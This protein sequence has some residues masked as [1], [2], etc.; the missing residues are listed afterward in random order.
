MNALPDNA[1]QQPATLDPAIINGRLDRLSMCRP[2]WVIVGQLSLAFFFE[3]YAIFVTG[4]IAPSLIH[5]G[6]LTATTQGLFG[7]TGVASFVAALFAGLSI[8]T[9]STG[10]L[11]DALGRRTVFLGALAWF[12]VASA[13]MAFQ[14]SAFGLN[15][16]RFIAGLGLGVEIV[17]I[18]TCI[19]EIVPKEARGRAFA[20]NQTLG[21]AAVPTVAFLSWFFA[22]HSWLGWDG[23][24]WVVAIGALGAMLAFRVGLELPESPRWLAARG[25]L[26]EADKLVGLLEMRVCRAT[27][28]PLAPLT[29]TTATG[30]H[31]GS[32]ADIWHPPFRRRALMLVVFNVFQTVG[33]YGF[34]NWAPTLLVSRGVTIVTSLMYVSVIALAAPLGPLLGLLFADRFERKHAIMLSAGLV[35]ALGLLFGLTSSAAVVIATGVGITLCQNILS[36]SYHA[37]QTELFPTPIRAKAVGFVYTWSRVSAMVSAFVIAYVLRSAGVAGVLALIAG[38]MLVV[39]AVI[40]TFGPLTLGRSVDGD[41]R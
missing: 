14:Q 27:G 22:S 11:A 18:A 4:Y 8:G 28:L 26:A 5:S 35:A 2:I 29:P 12:A 16:F 23:W 3:L 9:L 34:V 37:Y 15:L 38:A 20:F 30:Q 10:V 21:F 33:F 39:V 25:R 36:F 13:I 19:S 6:I 24:R 41:V 1:N 17:T 32:F 31:V 40:G 7:F